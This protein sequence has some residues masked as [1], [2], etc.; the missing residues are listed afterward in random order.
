MVEN[1]CPIA[2]LELLTYYYFGALLLF[3]SNIFYLRF[4]KVNLL[5]NVRA[6]EAIFYSSNYV[7]YFLNFQ[8]FVESIQHLCINI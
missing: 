7:K 8:Q 4:H 6:V 1:A 3:W 2:Q 5:L